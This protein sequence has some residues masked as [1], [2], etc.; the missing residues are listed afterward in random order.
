MVGSH[1][2]KQGAKA[3]RV[4]QAGK[5]KI[6]ENGSVKHV[7]Q[8]I[9][10]R[11]MIKNRSVPSVSCYPALPVNP[12]TQSILPH[13]S[14]SQPF[15]R[16]ARRTLCLEV[17]AHSWVPGSTRIAREDDFPGH[18]TILLAR[19][20]KQTLGYHQKVGL[21]TCLDSASLL[22]FELQNKIRK[23]KSLK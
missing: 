12:P 18:L 1:D 7:L 2:V 4:H 23:N 9:N 21:P 20:H 11:T 10:C 17:L 8:M 6:Y 22:G 16:Q 5:V 14:Y 3:L 15:A 19:N 13:P